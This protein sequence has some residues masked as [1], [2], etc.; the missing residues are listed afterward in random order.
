MP[1][2]QENATCADAVHDKAMD[3]LVRSLLAAL[4]LI[5]IEGDI[6]GAAAFT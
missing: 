4:V 6:H 2:R 5:D 3:Q 1:L